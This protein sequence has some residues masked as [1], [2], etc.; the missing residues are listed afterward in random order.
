MVSSWHRLGWART[1]PLRWRESPSQAEDKIARIA[2]D[3][4]PGAIVRELRRPA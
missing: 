4:L 3:G 1:R 2:F